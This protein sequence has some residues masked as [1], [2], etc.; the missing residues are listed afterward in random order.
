MT[1]EGMLTDL[2]S[3]RFNDDPKA[4]DEVENPDFDID[5]VEAQIGYTPK[6]NTVLPDDFE[7]V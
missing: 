4:L 5:D 1:V 2:W 6:N 7:D 3:H